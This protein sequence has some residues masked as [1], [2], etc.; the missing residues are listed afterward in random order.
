MRQSAFL[1]LLALASTAA[2]QEEIEV[3][4]AEEWYKSKYAP[5]YRDRP[6]EKVEEFS[7]YF[8]ESIHL[9][10]GGK[11]FVNSREWIS[12]SLEAW[13]MDGWIRSEIAELEF[14]LL[15]KSTASFKV[16]WNDSYSGGNIAHECGWYLAD[17][18][19]DRWL[20]S[21]YATISCSDHGL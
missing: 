17:F 5:L 18:S 6:W 10:D 14:D 11:S 4:S 21:E 7:E 15:N 3:P 1:A 16:K 9:H 2:A 20:I 19:E 13:K 8:A 12:D